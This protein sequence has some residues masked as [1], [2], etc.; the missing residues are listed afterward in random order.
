MTAQDPRD[1]EPTTPERGVRAWIHRH[2]NSGGLLA[3]IWF[4]IPLLL[5]IL[6]T[7]FLSN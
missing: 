2:R 4:G 5:V 7:L 3:L 6:A 1:Q